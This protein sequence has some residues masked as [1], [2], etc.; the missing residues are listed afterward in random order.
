MDQPNQEVG[1]EFVPVHGGTPLR[2]SRE[3]TQPNKADAEYW[4]SGLTMVY[5]EGA[6][7]R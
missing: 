1:I 7:E 5:L 3:T 4:A 6:L 2:S